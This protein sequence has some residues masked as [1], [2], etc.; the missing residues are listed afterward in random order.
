MARAEI[1][2]RAFAKA[3]GKALL[4][5]KRPDL[6]AARSF[7][8]TFPAAE[9]GDANPSLDLEGFLVVEDVVVT[10]PAEAE[11]IEFEDADV[12]GAKATGDDKTEQTMCPACTL[13]SVNMWS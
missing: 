13:I 9:G 11:D 1:A 4:R 5:P 2:S 6:G 10:F 8:A 3:T 12:D 7:F